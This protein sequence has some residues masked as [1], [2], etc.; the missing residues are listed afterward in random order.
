M[1]KW[2]IYEAY[3]M[4]VAEEPYTG[5]TVWA[6]TLDELKECFTIVD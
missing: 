5:R 1:E 3:G 2:H 4:W 6:L